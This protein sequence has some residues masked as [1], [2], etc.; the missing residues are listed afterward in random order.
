[1]L[2]NP[3]EDL[4]SWLL[5]SLMISLFS[6]ILTSLAVFLLLIL[7]LSAGYD[8]DVIIENE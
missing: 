7:L 5:F 4:G 1:M 3:W 2:Q 8:V 6:I